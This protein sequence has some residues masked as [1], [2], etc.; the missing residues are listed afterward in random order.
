MM[1]LTRKRR[2]AFWRLIANVWHEF[3]CGSQHQPSRE[4]ATGMENV[5][6]RAEGMLAIGHRRSSRIAGQRLSNREASTRKASAW[7]KV[8]RP[9]SWLN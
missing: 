3:T 1:Y 4:A 5:L 6:D 2:I 7:A 8:I 9:A